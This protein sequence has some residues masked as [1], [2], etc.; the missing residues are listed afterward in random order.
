MWLEGLEKILYLGGCC[1]LEIT[2]WLLKDLAEFIVA[3]AT[4][5]GCVTVIGN[6]LD[7]GNGVSSGSLYNVTDC[8]S[9]MTL[10]LMALL[11][12]YLDLRPDT[13]TAFPITNGKYTLGPLV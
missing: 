6:G 7:L 1:G 11:V 2:R 10:T 13:N 12:L 3:N 5:G 8:H 4:L 9:T